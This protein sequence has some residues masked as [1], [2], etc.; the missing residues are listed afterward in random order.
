[1]LSDK[2]R[3]LVWNAENQLEK[4]TNNGTTGCTSDVMDYKYDGDGNRVLRTD[5][6]DIT[7]YVNRW[8]QVD[9]VSG[10]PT[11]TVTYWQGG[12]QVASAEGSTIQ[13]ILSDHLGSP[14]AATDASGAILWE[15]RTYPFGAGRVNT[16]IDIE[17]RFTG[18]I[19]DVDAE[20][21]FYNARYMDL[22]TSGFISPDSI[23]PNPLDPR[24]HNRYS[25]VRNNPLKYTDP[26]GNACVDTG[27]DY[28]C[29]GGDAEM[30][31]IWISPPVTSPP[32]ADTPKTTI[33]FRLNPDGTVTK[34]STTTVV[35]VTNPIAPDGSPLFPSDESVLIIPVD[36]VPNGSCAGVFSCLFG[37]NKNMAPSGDGIL[38]Q[39]RSAPRSEKIGHEVFH[40]ADQQS[41][42]QGNWFVD[43]LFYREFF[44]ADAYRIEALIRDGQ[45]PFEFYFTTTSKSEIVPGPINYYRKP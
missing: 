8:Y 42:G 28:V 14:M 15:R 37:R 11:T 40:K 16:G 17:R 38:M 10:T 22:P 24:D 36:V 13:Y 29:D 3:M 12:E 5:S 9:D 21:F 1:M 43:Y 4:I 2:C 6:T 7:H 32:D 45:V 35:V 41:Y 44:E 34:T 30:M 25:Y 20:L 27:S 26:S 23:V 33:R 18:Q 31:G 39:E 19:Y